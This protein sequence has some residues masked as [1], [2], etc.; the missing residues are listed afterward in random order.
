M[1]FIAPSPEWYVREEAPFKAMLDLSLVHHLL[2]RMEAINQL[3]LLS[4]NRA[5]KL[6]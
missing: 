2:G 1:N 5:T 4:K 6:H 3:S